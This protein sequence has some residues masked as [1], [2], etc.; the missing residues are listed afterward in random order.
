MDG[1]SLQH[2]PTMLIRPNRFEK[3]TLL[4][5]W[6]LFS[7]FIFSF[8]V[9]PIMDPDFWW[10]LKTGEEMVKNWGLLQADPFTFTGD[11]VVS[12]RE[13]MILKGYWLWEIIA[14]GM[15]SLL[16]FNGILLLNIITLGATAGVVVHQIHRERVPYGIALPLLT[17][18]FF[19]VCSSYVWERPQMVSFLFAAILLGQIARVR[20]GGQLGWSLPLVMVIWA[21]MHGG[22]VVGDIIIL[23]F[24]VGVVI[25]YRHDLSRMKHLLLWSIIAIGSSLINPNGGLVLVEIF[26][27]H[28]STLMG[29]VAEY[30][31]TLS[32]FQNGHGIVAILWFLIVLYF[33]GV[34][35]NRRLF[36]PELIVALFLA[37]F[38]VK[39]ARNVGF[40]SLALLPTICK[41][42]HAGAVRLRWR[43]S[44]LISQ[45]ILVLCA[46]FLLWPS[47]G[48]L[49]GRSGKGPIV[50]FYPEKAISF[51]RE[52]GL[53]GRLYNSYE[54]GGYLL[55]RLAPEIKVFIDGRGLESRVFEDWEV[56]KRGSR[57]SEILLDSYKIDYIIQPIYQGDGSIQP[58]MKR[59]LDRHGWMPIYLD[60]QVYMFAH[61]TP[62]NAKIIDKYYID[63]NDFSARLLL[64]YNYLC[65][66]FPKEI[67]FQVARAGMM[68]HLS[69]YDEAKAQIEAIMS[70]APHDQSI[71]RLRLDLEI[72]RLK[73]LRQ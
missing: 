39:Y 3:T 28:D 65:R 52:S 15:Y 18:S 69:R 45:I 57:K 72:L 29:A 31:S 51:I 55:W 27:F 49:Q 35:G 20:D 50:N 54:N 21:N 44:P 9:R 26:T 40:F 2:E 12:N 43:F 70:I 64:M 33:V 32:R 14:Y 25:E 6:G 73:G 19:L 1:N 47:Y 7:L 8:A 59:L 41:S 34:W 71:P 61:I 24:A 53:Q 56:I 30:Q 46:A 10:H 42:L 58:L 16:K 11:A 22:F 5:F 17:F 13:L 68:L 37:Y 23:C 63:K 38:S 66:S 4:L 36:W 60:L 67:G 48:L 62:Q